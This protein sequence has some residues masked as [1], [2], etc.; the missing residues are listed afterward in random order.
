MVFFGVLL[1][2]RVLV[3]AGVETWLST[4]TGE[5]SNIA[6]TVFAVTTLVRAPTLHLVLR[7]RHDARGVLGHTGIPTDQ[8]H[9]VSGVGRR[10]RALRRIRF[11]R[12]RI[13][14]RRRQLLDRLDAPS[15]VPRSSPSACTDVLPGLH[16]SRV[17]PRGRA[18]GTE[19][20]P[21]LLPVVDWIP[22]HVLVVGIIGWAHRRAFPSWVAI[23]MIAAGAVR[24]TVV[25]PS[26][27]PPT[28][29]LEPGY[30]TSVRITLAAYLAGT[31]PR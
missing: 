25:R 2:V 30:G 31:C 5:M 6:L 29:K 3:G 19:P 4:W 18:M 17:E 20:L 10:V 1:V 28:N 12:N 8:L 14:A 21:S 7:E 9:R 23:A 26:L 13:A 11:H 15:S 24:S 27:R 16:R 22:M